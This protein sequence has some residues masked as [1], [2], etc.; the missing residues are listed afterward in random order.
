MFVGLMCRLTLKY[1]T[2]PCFFSRTWFASQPT[3]SR[4]GE[5]YSVMPS[6]KASRS[7]AS[8]FS[9]IGFNRWSVIVS[10]L[11]LYPSNVSNPPNR[12]RSAPE[13]QEQHT[14]IAVH[15]EKRSVQLAQIIRFDKRMFVSQ[16]RCDNGDSRPSRPRQSKAERQPTKKRDHSDMHSASDA[17]RF[18]NPEFFG[19]GEEPCAPVVIDILAC[20]EHVKPAHPQGN[21]G[22]K[23][24]HP[25]IEAARNGDPRGGRRD[26]QR[27]SEKKMRPIRKALRERI[28]KQNGDGQGCQL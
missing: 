9:L 7:P 17:Q 27:K 19:H 10:S 1:V 22:A 11:I 2:L 28:K 21:R 6:S 23:N 18:G 15:G 8:T 24:K 3:A 25:R 14:N 13:H 20:I 12:C 26:A 16:E 5:R 4:S